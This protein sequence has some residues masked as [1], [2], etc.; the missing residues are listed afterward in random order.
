MDMELVLPLALVLT[1]TLI[2]FVLVRRSGSNKTRLT[3]QLEPLISLIGKSDQ[4]RLVMF[5]TSFCSRCPSLRNQLLKFTSNHLSFSEVDLTENIA[6]AKQLNVNQTP[7][8]FLVSDSGELLQRFGPRTPRS[9]F[10]SALSERANYAG[11]SN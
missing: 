3:T 7:T 2:G 10:E 4:D 8:T 5:S 6:L 1:T 9:D 11:R